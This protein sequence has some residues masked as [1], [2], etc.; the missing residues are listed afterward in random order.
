[1][2]ELK[3]KG[4]TSSLKEKSSVTLSVVKSLVLRE[5]DE[6]LIAEGEEEIQSLA[7]FLFKSGIAFW[8]VLTYWDYWFLNL[9]VWHRIKYILRGFFFFLNLLIFCTSLLLLQTLCLLQIGVVRYRTRDVKESR[10]DWIR[11]GTHVLITCY[12]SHVPWHD[13]RMMW[14]FF[15]KLAWHVVTGVTCD[16]DR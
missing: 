10:H 1:M 6:K 13:H 8:I 2:S 3:S 5:K 4:D 9:L 11:H 14:P 7:S 12:D 15:G 16:Q